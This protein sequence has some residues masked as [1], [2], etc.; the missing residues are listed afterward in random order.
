MR[1]APRPTY[2]MCRA[3]SSSQAAENVQSVLRK[4]PHASALLAANT[5]IA[6]QKECQ[7]RS[8]VLGGCRC[9]RIAAVRKKKTASGEARN[10]DS[11]DDDRHYAGVPSWQGL[12]VAHLALQEPAVASIHFV[13]DF[14]PSPPNS[15]AA[16]E[17][18]LLPP[19]RAPFIAA[20]S[21]K[22]DLRSAVMPAASPNIKKRPS[23]ADG[24]AGLPWN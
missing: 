5:P 7:R 22:R 1:I 8:A 12:D 11:N 3:P 15:L 23:A 19:L 24:V 18:P 4:G 2:L 13:L 6:I 9:G 10:E 14:Q 20:R 21:M 16:S 17:V